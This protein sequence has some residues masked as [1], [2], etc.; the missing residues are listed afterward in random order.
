VLELKL[1]DASRTVRFRN[2]VIGPRVL[3]TIVRYPAVGHFD[4]RDHSNARPALASG[5]FPLIVFGHGFGVTPALYA[6]LLRAWAAAG[7]VVAAPAF[8]LTEAQAPGGPLR[9]D[10]PN[11]PADLSFVITRMLDAHAGSA[12]PLGGL[13]APN[14]IAVAGQ[15]DGG[16]TAL[17]AAYDAPYRDRRIDAAVILSGA[18]DPFVRGFQIAPGGPPLLATQGTADPINPPSATAAFF[19]PAPAPKYLLQLIGAS[20]LPPYSTDATQLRVVAKVTTAFL[21]SY[22]KHQPG[23]LRRMR[24]AA[25]VPG[26]AT[27]DSDPPST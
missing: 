3:E 26:V 4:G 1:V 7:Y 20:H 22:L 5:P 11:Q 21:D 8:P 15:S 17:A 14:A 13:I 24:A 2:G 12:P 6:P 9:S 16:D 25:S 27:L 10:L 18:E 23:A 19:D